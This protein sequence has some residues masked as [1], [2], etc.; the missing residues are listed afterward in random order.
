MDNHVSLGQHVCPIC[1]DVHDSGEVLLATKYM[2]A[3]GG[4]MQPVHPLKRKTVTGYGLCG[5][6]KARTEAGYMA[7]IG[8]DPTKSNVEKDGMEP[9][10][11]STTLAD[12]YRTG[13]V[14]FVKRA[15]L[16]TLMNPD[17]TPPATMSAMETEPFTFVDDEVI[18][19]FEQQA[20]AAG[21]DPYAQ[22][23]ANGDFNVH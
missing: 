13:R 11:D 1:G 19:W 20:V 6:C 5:S 15:V 14:C 12:V 3:R 16:L 22:Q 18:D 21:V 2:P 17:T 10:V 23:K 4:G 7:L 9:G 8:A